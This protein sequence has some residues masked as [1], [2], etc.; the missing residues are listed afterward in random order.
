MLMASVA[1]AMQA[2]ASK[3]MRPNVRALRYVKYD[4]QQDG[5]VSDVPGS[6]RV[7]GEVVSRS[8]PYLTACISSFVSFSFQPRRWTPQLNSATP[9]QFFVV[10]K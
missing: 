2:V 8:K 10:A 5:P 1:L 9:Q 6:F 7:L 4:G 3:R